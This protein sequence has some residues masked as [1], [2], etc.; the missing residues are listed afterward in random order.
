MA[1]PTAVKIVEVGP[2]DGLQNEKQLLNLETKLTFIEK[3]TETGLSYI[4][5][6]SF[7]SEKKIPQMAN[8]Y[9][10]I[11]RLPKSNQIQ[12]AVLV[13]NKQGLEA[14]IATHCKEIS[15]FTGA[16]NTFCQK[17]INCT[18]DQSFDIY[19]D[20][21]KVA[22]DHKIK[23]RGYLSCCF[24]CPYEGNV[25]PS[26][27]CDLAKKLI[28][29][30]CYEVSL[31]DTIGVATPGQVRALLQKLKNDV[32]INNTAVHFHDT[33]GQAL[34]NIYGSLLEG[35][36]VID[37]STAGLGGCP[38]AVGASGNVATEDVLYMLQGLG[39]STGVN[40]SKVIDAGNYI[41]KALKRKNGSKVALALGQDF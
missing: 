33:Y 20:I 25:D 13:P 41:T 22:L 38:Y 5:A 17:N 4:E 2:R 1:L 40:L 8:T 37:S 18:I 31:G 30:G 21:C 3:L 39:I 32:P 24:G 11:Q 7:V 35:I 27:V 15:I 14:A 29:I 6:G 23:V 19:K 34:G 28:E 10:I 36:S 26:T 16:S 12:Y 9:E